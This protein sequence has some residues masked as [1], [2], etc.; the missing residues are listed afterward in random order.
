MPDAPCSA[1]TPRPRRPSSGAV[2]RA[3][4]HIHDH[5]CER[6]S[7]EDLA[8]VAQLSVFRFATV[9]RRRVGVPPHRYICQLRVQRAQAL[10]RDG[11]PAAIVA[12]Q[13]G[14]FDQS[15][16]SRHFRSACG[17]TPG[18]YVMQVRNGEAHQ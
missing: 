6:L 16:L 12:N 1:S 4:K 10:L 5:F 11:V 2:K 3:L 7:L 18:Q 14:F 17:M 15:H 9:F 13:A 8:A